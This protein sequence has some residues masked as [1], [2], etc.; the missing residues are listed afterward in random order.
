VFGDLAGRSSAAKILVRIGQRFD[1]G[2]HTHDNPCDTIVARRV[3]SIT[4]HVRAGIP[5]QCGVGHHECG[6][7][8][9]LN[10]QWWVH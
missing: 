3:R 9:F 8:N 1:R 5:L 2:T 7:S 4:A 10:D 6:V